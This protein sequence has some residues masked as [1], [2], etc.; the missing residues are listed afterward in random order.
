MNLKTKKFAV[1]SIAVFFSTAAI[2]SVSTK[3]TLATKG[4]NG[5]QRSSTWSY[6]RSH[7]KPKKINFKNQP[8][9]P[10]TCPQF[11][12]NGMYQAIVNNDLKLLDKSLKEYL[13]K[14]PNTGINT[15]VGSNKHTL[16]YE[17]VY[18]TNEGQKPLQKTVIDGKEYYGICEYLL[19]QGANPNEQ[20]ISG[21]TAFHAAALKKNKYLCGLL[22][23]YGANLDIKNKYKIKAIDTAKLL[24]DDRFYNYLNFKRTSAKFKNNK[25]INSKNPVNVSNKQNN[26]LNNKNSS[27]MRALLEIIEHDIK[28]ISSQ[29][30]PA[31][32]AVKPSVTYIQN[33]NMSTNNMSFSRGNP[34]INTPFNGTTYNYYSLPSQP[35]RI[36]N[37]VLLVRHNLCNPP[38][39]SPVYTYY[40]VHSQ[41]PNNYL[42]QQNP[43]YR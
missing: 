33:N 43:N 6:S 3:H 19:K 41:T 40:P 13:K 18:Y 11:G 15:K 28:E 34:Y 9:I 31:Q 30:V 20:T 14:Y 32:Q 38:L 37:N 10:Y 16:L 8:F 26:N 7:L 21:N 5:L 29:N 4:K 24:H 22:I 2:L 12:I 39:C 17:A 25:K 27:S 1:K 36:P 35:V 42:G 23:D